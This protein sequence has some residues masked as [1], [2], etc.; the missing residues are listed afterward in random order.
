M[1]RIVS[2]L[3]LWAIAAASFA[4]NMKDVT[5]QFTEASSLTLAGKAFTNTTQPYQRMDFSKSD[6][7]SE[8]DIA[9]LVMSSGIIVAFETD[10][11]I[12]TVKVE[13]DKATESNSSSIA[14]RGFDLYIKKDGKWL[15]AGVACCRVSDKPDH[16]QVVSYMDDSLKECI[17]YLPTYSSEKSVQIGTKEGSIIRPGKEPFRHKICLHGSSFMHGSATSRAAAT[18]PGFLSRLTGLQFCSLGVGG[19]CFMQESFAEAL[20]YADVEAFVFDAFSNGSA[21]TIESNLFPFIESIQSAKP[22]VPLIFMSSIYREKRNFDKLHDKLEADKD[23]MAR[24]MMAE[25]VKKYKDVYFIESNASNEWHETTCD[26]THPGDLG[27][28]IWANSVKDPIVEI[29]A[30]YGIK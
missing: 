12:I 13:W 11:P 14:N 25:A 1:K 15:W 23:A 24:K 10:S 18:V 21:K 17:L 22:G 8:K 16:R 6:K 9:R 19:D 26:G 28:W 5:F 4:Q 30:K 27:Y 2:I 3:V 20:R 29:L 7:W